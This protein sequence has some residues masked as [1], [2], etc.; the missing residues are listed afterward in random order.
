MDSPGALLRRAKHI[1]RKEGLRPLLWR[2]FRYLKRILVTYLNVYLYEH[3][4]S[5]RN[6][7]DFLPRIHDFT[8]KIVHSNAE[9][10]RLAA[11]MGCDFRQDFIGARAGL[12]K[13][14]VA[15]CVFVNGDIAHIGWVGLSSEAKNSFDPVPYHVDFSS[16]EACTGGTYTVPKYRGMGLMA[17]VYCKRFEYLRERGI[18]VS[19]NAVTVDNAASQ[20]VHAKFG[21]RIYARARYLRVLNLKIWRERPVGH[22]HRPV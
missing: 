9:A 1:F 16:G 13:G 8:F 14:A 7:S 10:D 5:E 3:T 15:F 6:E 17:Y 20:K 2:G 21:P 4:L 18:T 19:R 22:T 11:T 12:D